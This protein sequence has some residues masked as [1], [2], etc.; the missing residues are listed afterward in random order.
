[1]KNY[2]TLFL[3]FAIFPNLSNKAAQT[4]KINELSG[5]YQQ[6]I[7]ND[8]NKAL[9][10]HY[11]NLLGAMLFKESSYGKCTVGDNGNAIGVLQLHKTMI[12]EANRILG[13]EKY[14]YDDRASI[15][16]SIEV[17]LIYQEYW[18]PTRN[19]ETAARIWNAGPDA[20][21]S[22]QALDYWTSIQYY[23]ENPQNDLLADTL[24][25]SANIQAV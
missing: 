23:M 15:E 2:L 4:G 13:Y 21:T 24:I 16:K 22:N 18:N 3:L 20:M 9:I 12:D 25:N 17:F 6:F 14:T 11:K 7:S 1:M 19:I 8:K 5:I 10:D